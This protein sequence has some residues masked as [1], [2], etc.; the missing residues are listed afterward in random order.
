MFHRVEL[1]GHIGNHRTDLVCVCQG[2]IEDRLKIDRIG[3]KMLRQHEIMVLE[4]VPQLGC[5][6]LAVVKIVEPYGTP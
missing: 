1:G 6:A 3:P 4:D 5:E 2:L